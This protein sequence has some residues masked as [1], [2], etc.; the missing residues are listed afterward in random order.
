MHIYKVHGCC[1]GAT[2]PPEHPCT[3]LPGRLAQSKAMAASH[4]DAGLAHMRSQRSVCFLLLRSHLLGVV[5]DFTMMQACLSPAW[6]A[7]IL[8]QPT[9]YLWV[10]SHMRPFQLWMRLFNFT[11]IPSG[12]LVLRT[13]GFEPFLCG[14]DP[15]SWPWVPL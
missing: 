2:A 14:K 8:Q 13:A 5:W 1:P 10:C 3:E 4:Q 6:V 11:G 7:S 12:S 9:I 15:S